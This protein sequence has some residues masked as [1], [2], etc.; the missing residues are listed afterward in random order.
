MKDIILLGD[1][2]VYE[3]STLNRESGE[4]VSLRYKSDTLCKTPVAHMALNVILFNRKHNLI[5]HKT[6]MKGHDKQAFDLSVS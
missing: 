2:E 1:S 3:K 6:E 4:G 5:C